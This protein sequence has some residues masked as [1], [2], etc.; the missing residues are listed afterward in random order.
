MSRAK[1]QGFLKNISNM[2]K[3]SFQGTIV[4]PGKC[5][6]IVI[7]TGINTQIGWYSY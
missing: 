3:I 6:G 7:G 2:F 4:A 1:K 5:T